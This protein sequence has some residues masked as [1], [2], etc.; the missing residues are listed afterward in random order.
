VEVVSGD[1]PDALVNSCPHVA[2]VL[3]LVQ[4]RQRLLKD[5]WLT[6]VGHVRPGMKKGKPLPEAEH[7]AEELDSKIRALTRVP[8][9][10]D[11]PS[12]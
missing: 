8:C 10:G 2:E 7:D 3:E 6:H 5:A 9:R 4:Q 1:S 11:S 12:H